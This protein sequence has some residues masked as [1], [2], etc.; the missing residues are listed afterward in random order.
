M[1]TSLGTC[2]AVM[3]MFRTRWAGAELIASRQQRRL[4]SLIEYARWHSPF[5]RDTYS[6]FEQGIADL[7]TLPVVTKQ[8]LMARLEDVVTDRTVTRRGVDAFL[9][10]PDNLGR[11]FLGR[12]QVVTSSGSTGHPGVFLLDERARVLSFALIEIRG[13]LTNWFRLGELLR[14]GTSGR[15]MALVAVRGA[16]YGALT[17]LEWARREHPSMAKTTQFISV[18]DPLDRQVA[19]LNEFGPRGVA[20]YPSAIFLLAREQAAG[21][22]HIDPLFI[23]LAGENISARAR[24]FI[25]EVFRCDTY[26]MYA[27]SENG[28][29]AIGCREGWL[30]A[31]TDWYVLEPVD[32][33]FRPV[34]PGTLS[35]TVLVTNL[36]NRLMPLIRYDQGDRV[37]VRPDRCPCGNPFPALRVV[38]RTDDLLELRAAGG[39][40]TI[41]LAAAGIATAIEETAGAYRLQ[42]VERSPADLEIRLQV[43]PGASREGVWAAAAER[44]RCYLKDNGVD[45]ITLHLSGEAPMPHPA[46]GKYAQVV[47]LR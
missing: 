32:A 17:A 31:N 45:T 28:A 23:I 1:S 21:R 5:Y 37:L 14:F 9:A 29:M 39:Q 2:L 33:D 10:S 41:T 24:R 34:A 22:M 13:G 6:R 36:M 18:L 35:H 16:H 25:E 46:S 4:S 26:E 11:A 20:G 7:A 44:V 42:V 12:Y 27:S 40:G 8:Q 47:K 15:R 43:M 19:Q 30:H 38:G 3:D